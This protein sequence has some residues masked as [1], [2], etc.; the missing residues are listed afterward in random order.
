MQVLITAYSQNLHKTGVAS[1]KKTKKYASTLKKNS[2]LC[3]RIYNTRAQ[4]S[5][6]NLQVQMATKLLRFMNGL[7]SHE[8]FGILFN[9]ISDDSIITALN[10]MSQYR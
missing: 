8:W 6:L 5:M 4:I 1:N 3:F 2:G 9:M 10:N 7:C